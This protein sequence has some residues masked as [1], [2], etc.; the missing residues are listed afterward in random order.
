[1]STAFVDDIITGWSRTQAGMIYMSLRQN[2]SK[3]DVAEMTGTSVQNVRNVL[4]N[5]KES[6]VIKY[7][8]RNTD[9]FHSKVNIHVADDRL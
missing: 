6:L 8:E 9:L 1:M 4:S 5:A 2:V 7:I 3:K